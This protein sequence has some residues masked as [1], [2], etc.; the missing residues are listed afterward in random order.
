ME[1]ARRESHERSLRSCDHSDLAPA[2]LRPQGVFF[3]APAVAQ[4]PPPRSRAF[5]AIDTTT[6]RGVNRAP[7]LPPRV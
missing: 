3:D 5:V 2:T 6:L 1:S 7:D 4:L